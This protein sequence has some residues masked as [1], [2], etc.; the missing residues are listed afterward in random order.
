MQGKRFKPLFD[1]LYWWTFA[2]TELLVLAVAIVPA[3][4]EPKTLF[5]TVP[6]LLFVS[7]FLIS[8]FFGYIELRESALFI[9]YGLILK[10]EIPYGKIR[11]LECG[12]GIISETMMSLKTAVSHVNIK[13]NSF[14]VTAVSVKDSEAFIKELESRIRCGI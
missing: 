7:Y 12:R 4:F 10:K 5:W 8:P 9:K 14:D 13:Y 6:V 2:P 11:K 1:K 3:I